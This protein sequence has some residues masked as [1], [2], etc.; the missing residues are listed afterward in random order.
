MYM[1]HGGTSFGFTS[2]SNLPPFA[3]TPTSYDYDAPISEAGD[4]T[5]KYFQVQE[6]ISKY[7]PLPKIAVANTTKA[8]YGPVEMR[9]L[10]SIQRLADKGLLQSVHSTYPLS[11]EQVGQNA[12]FVMYETT[13]K[14]SPIDPAL[15][16]VKGIADRG[17]V[18]V[19][20]TFAGVLSRWG[21]KHGGITS[22]PLSVRKGQVIQVFFSNYDLI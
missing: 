11:F 3:P 6:V 7:L 20:G 22:M 9:P 21:R 5:Q 1:A 12:G 16:E 10:G 17:Y 13:V 14:F 4:L 8:A 18:Y 19:Q 2:G 15:L